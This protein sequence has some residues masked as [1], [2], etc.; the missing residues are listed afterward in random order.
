M[1]ILV[2]DD[3]KTMRYVL[4]TALKEIGYSSIITAECVDVAKTLLA[5][6]PIPG[7]IISDWNMPGASGLDFLKYVRSNTRT[8]ET[9]FIMLTTETDRNKIVEATRAGLQSYL[10]KP[11]KKN[12]LAEKMRELSAAYGFPPPN[13]EHQPERVKVIHPVSEE[14]QESHPL[15]GVV[16]NEHIAL[17]LDAYN[18][19]WNGELSRIGFE[20]E[21][22]RELFKSSR[23]NKIEEIELFMTTV[24]DAACDAIKYNLLKI[25]G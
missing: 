22:A 9:P 6:D 11:V 8:K 14:D 10:L 23:E 13:G 15:K 18:K 21:I 1:K 19:V 5:A 20:E 7:L 16:K 2:V 25:V 24:L 3:S 17:V 12:V 4:I